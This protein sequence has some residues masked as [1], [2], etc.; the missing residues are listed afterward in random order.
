MKFVCLSG[1]STSLLDSVLL[2]SEGEITLSLL[3]VINVKFPLEPH[4]KYN[5]TQ[6]GELGF[7]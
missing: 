3:R 4:Q 6:Y 5:I 2:S 7:S 1:K